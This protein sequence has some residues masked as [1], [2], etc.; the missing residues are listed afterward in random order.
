MTYPHA[1]NDYCNNHGKKNG[2][3][4]TENRL[5]VMESGQRWAQKLHWGIFRSA[6]F[7]DL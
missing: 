7:L 5:M 1:K 2:V 4:K 3:T 6:G